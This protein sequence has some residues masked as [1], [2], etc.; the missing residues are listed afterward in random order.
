MFAQY[1][2]T[3]DS[4]YATRVR[5]LLVVV[6]NYIIFY[7][8]KEEKKTMR[9]NS[10]AHLCC[11]KCKTMCLWVVATSMWKLMWSFLFDRN[12]LIGANVEEPIKTRQAQEPNACNVELKLQFG[13]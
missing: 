6:Y 5:S 3:I 11:Q 7:L 13:S 9:N 4:T 2:G 8:R 10:P 12:L 1:M